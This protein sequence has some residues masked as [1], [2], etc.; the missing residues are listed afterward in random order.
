MKAIIPCHD[1]TASEMRLDPFTKRPMIE[2]ILKLCV[3]YRIE[4][5]IITTK[6]KANL[7]GYCEEHGIETLII[8]PTDEW[9]D[10]VL[11][12]KHLWHT[13]NFLM[14]PNTRFTPV[15][16]INHMK[17]DME[18]G[19]NSSIALHEVENNSKWYTVCDYS[20]TNEPLKIYAGMAMG[21]MAFN[22]IE[23]EQLFNIIK[24]KSTDVRLFNSSFRYL[25][26]F[27]DT[28]QTGKA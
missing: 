1:N 6:D 8:E 3:K 2:F 25:T 5:L 16:I 28:T 19:A 13:I 7:I 23:G 9:V 17:K 11:K 21:T 26:T 4:P 20:I 12:S 14:F 27:K 24:T 10:A 18:L 22:N 15:D